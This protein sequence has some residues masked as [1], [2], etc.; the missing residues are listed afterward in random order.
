MITGE[1]LLTLA[2]ISGCI[3]FPN[4]MEEQNIQKATFSFLAWLVFAFALAG[5]WKL[6]WRGKK[7]IIY[8]ISAMILLTIAYFGSRMMFEVV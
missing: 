4:F 5:H 7:M 8:S 1:F 6:N 3:Y 2:L